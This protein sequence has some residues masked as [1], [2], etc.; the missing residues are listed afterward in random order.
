MYHGAVTHKY[1]KIMERRLTGEQSVTDPMIINDFVLGASSFYTANRPILSTAALRYRRG[2]IVRDVNGQDV[3]TT[4]DA[5]KLE[6][7]A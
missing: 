3:R 6:H 4:G 7:H 2:S 5:N 1:G